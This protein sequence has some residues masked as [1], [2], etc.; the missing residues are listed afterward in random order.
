MFIIGFKFS[1]TMTGPDCW[2][3]QLSQ[4]KGY[5]TIFLMSSSEGRGTLDTFCLVHHRHERVNIT[6]VRKIV[7]ASD[8][9]SLDDAVHGFKIYPFHIY[10]FRSNISKI[11]ELIAT[12]LRYKLCSISSLTRPFSY[13]ENYSQFQQYIDFYGI[14]RTWWFVVSQLISTLD[15][16]RPTVVGESGH[17]RTFNQKCRWARQKMGWHTRWV[18]SIW[19]INIAGGL[20]RAI[21][22]ILLAGS[23][24]VV[25]ILV[26]ICWYFG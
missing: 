3:R 13:L 16:P 22:A 19:V 17:D 26:P 5:D 6:H 2:I 4:Y 24:S 21:V 11:A 25:T 15:L 20:V 9:S 10:F 1:S 23:M 7:R 14:F 8:W 12:L 18:N